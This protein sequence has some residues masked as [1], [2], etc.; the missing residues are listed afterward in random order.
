MLF[1]RKCKPK[2][3]LDAVIKAA[4]ARK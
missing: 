2:P 1:D 3:A 4:Q